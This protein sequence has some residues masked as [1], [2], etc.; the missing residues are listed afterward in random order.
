MEK[1][2]WL[3]NIII[4]MYIDKIKLVIYNLRKKTFFFFHIA[5]VIFIFCF[6]KTHSWTGNLHN[7]Y[8]S[9]FVSVIVECV[10]KQI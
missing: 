1:F 8:N 9:N 3:V 7:V 6:T 5:D 10:N 4:I 2:Q